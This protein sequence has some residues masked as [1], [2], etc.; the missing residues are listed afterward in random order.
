MVSE[1]K[2]KIVCQINLASILRICVVVVFSLIKLLID[3]LKAPLIITHYIIQ[4]TNNKTEM[5]Y[6]SKY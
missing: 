3:S 4:H 1:I 6:I 5:L 2:K